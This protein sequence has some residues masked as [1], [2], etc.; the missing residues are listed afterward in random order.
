MIDEDSI[1]VD[2]SSEYSLYYNTESKIITITNSDESYGVSID[3]LGDGLFKKGGKNRER[4][5]QRRK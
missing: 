3:K 1:L 5:S 2:D 4:G